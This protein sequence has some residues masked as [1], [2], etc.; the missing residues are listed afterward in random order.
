[1]PIKLSKRSKAPRTV[2]GPLVRAFVARNG[3][4]VTAA[5]VGTGPAPAGMVALPF[6]R[7]ANDDGEAAIAAATESL[8]ALLTAKLTEAGQPVAVSRL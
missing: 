4:T 1:M 6:G 8:A 5:A 7:R 2:E 3:A